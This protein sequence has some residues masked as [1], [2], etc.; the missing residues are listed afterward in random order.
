[1]YHGHA[2]IKKMEGDEYPELNWE[3]AFKLTNESERGAILI[4]ATKVEEYL[5]KLI[6][7]ILP[8]TQKVYRNRLLKYP[9]PLSSFSGKIELLY[10]FRIIDKKVYDSLNRLREIRNQA[11]HSSDEFTLQ[12]KKDRLEMIYSFEEFF[13]EIVHNL[14]FDNL[15]KWEKQRLKEGLKEKFSHIDYEE[16]WNSSI[17]DPTQNPDIQGHL[18]IWKLAYGLTLLCLKI[19]VI[20]DDYSLDYKSIFTWTDILKDSNPQNTSPFP[21]V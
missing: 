19:Q 9:G 10:A 8:I 14:A 11:A 12:Q 5:I 13:P 7:I 17:P 6:E 20:I 1:M 2:I 15:I 3:F 18:T 16:L 21:G 4:G